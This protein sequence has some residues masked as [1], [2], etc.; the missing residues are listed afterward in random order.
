MLFRSE[1]FTEEEKLRIT[2]QMKQG[3]IFLSPLLYRPKA[4]FWL[5]PSNFEKVDQ[6]MEDIARETGLGV[7]TLEEKIRFWREAIE[8]KRPEIEEMGIKIPA[9]HEIGVEGVEVQVKKTETIA[10]TF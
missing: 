8:K 2:R 10:T 4:D 1:Q 7:L 5:L 3:F 6:Q 9:I